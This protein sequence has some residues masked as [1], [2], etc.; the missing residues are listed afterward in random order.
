MAVDVPD[1][2][3]QTQA[4]GGELVSL[5]TF[6]AV[7]GE[8]SIDFSSIASTYSILELVYVW[9]GAA[10]QAQD[11]FSIQ[12]NG[13][14]TGGNYEFQL[15][16]GQGA[17]APTTTNGN[18]L[19]QPFMPCDSAFA[20]VPGMGRIRIPRYADS[21][22]LKFASVENRVESSGA[23]GGT[24]QR[25]QDGFVYWNNTAA[26]N[27][28]TLVPSVTTLKVGSWAVLFGYL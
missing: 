22:F 13:D 20:N 11:Q 4:L 7:G 12:F 26:I 24:L 17:N 19:I 21:H 9:R 16:T 3:F 14:I 10:A 6:T 2:T 1:W 28:V 5:A 27:R 23:L 15:I 25:T 8:A 18:G